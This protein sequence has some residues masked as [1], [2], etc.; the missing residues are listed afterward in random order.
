[1]K[2]VAPGIYQLGSA[3]H[4]FF[5]VVEGGKATVVDAG[6]SKELPAL[7]KGLRTLGLGLGDVAVILLTHAHADHIGF[8]NEANEGG[9]AVKA[10]DAE[11]PYVRGDAE[12]HAIAISD[13]PIWKPVTWGFLASMVRAGAMTVSKVP[14][15]ETF[16]DGDVLDI[17]G[18]PRVVATPGHTAGHAVF[19]FEGSRAVCTGDAL[20]TA[21]LI[22]SAVGPQML[23][24][25]F[26]ADV[27]EANASLDTLA[28]LDADLL[29]PGHGDPWKGSPADAVALARQ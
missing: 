26:H 16:S 11:A 1:M 21:G 14:N 22:N 12:G 5:V 28:S 9:V 20:V 10:L 4:N 2:Q 27:A 19:L 29:L 3:H 17:P 23:A 15:V 24:D 7:R 18:R 8:A 25:M 13:M 6:A